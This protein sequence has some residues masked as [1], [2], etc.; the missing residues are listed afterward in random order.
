MVL[1]DTA[2]LVVNQCSAPPPPRQAIPERDPDRN[3]KRPAKRVRAE[4]IGCPD[5]AAWAFRVLLRF[6]APCP[7]RL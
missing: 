4:I 3:L 5:G 2:L 6:H 7:Q 1:S